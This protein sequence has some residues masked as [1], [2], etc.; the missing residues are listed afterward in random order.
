MAG[1]WHLHKLHAGGGAMRLD[2]RRR[3]RVF[4]VRNDDLVAMPMCEH[5]V[6]PKVEN[7][8]RTL[9]CLLAVRRQLLTRAAVEEAGDW[10]FAAEFTCRERLGDHEAQHHAPRVLRGVCP[11]AIFALAQEGAQLL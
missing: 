9:I 6:G 10:T 2:I 5:E 8:F 11:A 3:Q 1:G 7:R 4:V